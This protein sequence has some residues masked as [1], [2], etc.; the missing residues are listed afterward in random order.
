MTAKR[1]EAVS[2]DFQAILS[3]C[4]PN[5]P[6]NLIDQMRIRIRKLAG[7]RATL[8]A[9]VLIAGLPA[10][11]SA[12]SMWCEA[13]RVDP[14]NWAQERLSEA[15][16]VILGRVYSIKEVP[17]EEPESNNSDGATSMT[18]LL[19]QIEAEQ[20]LAKT[21]FD[22]VVSFEVIKAWK[23]PIHPIVR[24]KVYLGRLKE[25]RSFREGDIYLVAGR[26][27]EGTLYRIESRCLD[28][29]IESWTEKY[30]EAL[31]SL[32]PTN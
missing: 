15:D 19:R 31:D 16:T 4:D 9:I 13:P 2:Q 18:E 20:E 32:A 11:V 26:D 23:D 8:C 25:A 1:S 14:A 22:H 3:A 29:I 27:L 17:P 5:Q 24:T 10:Q 21:R 12:S 30:V 6:L 7:T 28:A